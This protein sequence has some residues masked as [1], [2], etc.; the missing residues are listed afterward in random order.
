[1]TYHHLL[2]RKEGSFTEEMLIFKDLSAQELRTQFVTPFLSSF[3]NNACE[4]DGFHPALIRTRIIR[5]K[6]PHDDEVRDYLR[7]WGEKAEEFMLLS[8]QHISSEHGDSAIAGAGEDV[9]DEFLRTNPSSQGAEIGGAPAR[10]PTGKNDP[11]QLGHYDITGVLGKSARRTVYDA[12]DS[13]SHRR[14][15]IMT[16]LMSA[17]DENAAREYSIM[18]SREARAVARLT[19][20]NIVQ[21]LDFGEEGDFAYIVMEFIAGKELKSLFDTSHRFEAKETVSIM[22]D[23]CAALHFAHEAGAIHRD[24]KPANVIIAAGGRAMLTDFGVAHFADEGSGANTSE[25]SGALIGTP[26]YMSPEAITGAA[27]DRRTDIFSAGVILYQLLTGEKPFA[28]PG[29]W[30]TV[31]NILE[32]DPPPPSSIN[33]GRSFSELFDEAAG[34]A[35]AKKVENRYQTARELD[36]ALQSALR[37]DIERRTSDC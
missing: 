18:F 15:A 24:V 12:F 31:K 16:V 34:K 25:T 37:H 1:M 5:T 32:H 28:G 6:R 7:A 8:G 4:A 13:T 29:T 19:H 3:N 2:V 23:L 26:A 21:V 20:P 35:L 9:T 30:T 22:R 14:V 36:L 17:L 11:K 10:S 33:K 27:I